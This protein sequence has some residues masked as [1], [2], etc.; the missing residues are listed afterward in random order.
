MA[1]VLHFGALRQETLATTLT[2]TG[3]AGATGLG[4]HARTKTVL[5]FAGSL[6]WLV[7]AFHTW[8]RPAGDS[9]GATLGVLVVLSIA[10]GIIFRRDMRVATVAALWNNGCRNERSRHRAGHLRGPR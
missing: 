5:P 10:R 1:G 7:S 6:G 2:A 8:S 3:E 4:A 9:G